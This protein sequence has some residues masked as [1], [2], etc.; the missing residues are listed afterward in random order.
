MSE[1]YR[2]GTE[3]ATAKRQDLLRR[4][5]DE[6]VTMPHAVRRVVVARSAWIASGIAVTLAGSAL[7]LAS[8]I[9]R[10]AAWMTTWLPGVEPAPLAT[11]LGVTW[12]VGVV[13]WAMGRARGEHRFAVA[14][15][16]F[17]LPSDDL[18]HDIE[19]LDHERPDV[20]ARQMAH[21]LEV[22][23]AAWPVIAVA[24]IL[25]A[26]SLYLARA[27]RIRGWPATSELEASLEAHAGTLIAIAIAGAI[28][29][30]AMTRRS[31]RLP[32]AANIAGGLGVV[33]A[34]VTTG[35]V[36]AGSTAGL[37]M[38]GVAIGSGAVGLV[39]RRLRRERN[40]IAAEDPAAGSEVF[41]IRGVLRSLR[42][43][44]STAYRTIRRLR[45]YKAWR[46]GVVGT[47]AAGAIAI[48]VVRKPESPAAAKPGSVMPQANRAEPRRAALDP[49]Y[50]IERV[51]DRFQIDLVLDGSPIDIPSLSDLGM[52]PPDWHA[53][54]KIA[55]DAE[56]AI[57][58]FET[59]AAA[60]VLDS[61]NSH[62]EFRIDNCDGRVQPLG[63][64]VAPRTN[65][66]GPHKVTLYVTPTL[67]VA[68]CIP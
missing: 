34:L 33:A 56:V 31:L 1:I 11:L 15:S 53:T 21:H 43:A 44:S 47:L 64:H 50:R 52:V 27:A 58:P 7:I 38:S 2:D 66:P 5:R 62:G 39:G 22:R 60:I 14:M 30:I 24:L 17:V 55:S 13:A 19:R 18:D 41:T 61:L 37:W 54:V 25:P 68:R 65:Q 48:V 36:A 26:T 20:M 57:S 42:A 67:G 16:K 29:A 49:A 32:I 8:A 3:G 6:L 4:R 45:G 9:P 10:V 35:L 40:Q 63:L 46:F 59:T 12:I 23:S 51:G 28:A